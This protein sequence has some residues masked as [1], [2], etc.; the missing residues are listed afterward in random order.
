MISES[1]LN[2]VTVVKVLI[3][4]RNYTV[5]LKIYFM[6]MG[7]ELKI[8]TMHVGHSNLYDLVYTEAQFK[9]TRKS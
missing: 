8:V 4:T 2:F 9:S 1:T 6:I 5:R 7:V 3:D